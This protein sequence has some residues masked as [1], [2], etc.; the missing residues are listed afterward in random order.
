ML[1]DSTI[2]LA[3]AVPLAGT[4]SKMPSFAA[5][6]QDDAVYTYD[7]MSFTMYDAFRASVRASLGEARAHMND[8]I[9][10]GIERVLDLGDQLFRL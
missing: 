5:A 1:W 6:I 10:Q 9:H 2:S 8:M 7:I 4:A 3:V